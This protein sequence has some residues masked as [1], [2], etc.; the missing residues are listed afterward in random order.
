MLMTK[1]ATQ[2]WIPC[3]YFVR[4]DIKLAGMPPTNRPLSDESS[5]L[6]TECWWISTDC[7]VIAGPLST[8]SSPDDPSLCYGKSFQHQSKWHSLISKKM[9]IKLIVKIN[10]VNYVA[11][12]LIIAPR[13]I[14]KISLTI[15]WVYY[16][17]AWKLK[18]L[19]IFEFLVWL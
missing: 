12:T 16:V 5:T 4:A 7:W 17:C 11:S 1:S 19:I 15:N 13:E 14:Y 2:P 10:F 6:L 8:I 3:L 18:P 9:R